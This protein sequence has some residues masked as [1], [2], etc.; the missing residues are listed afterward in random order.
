MT[1]VTQET[2]TYTNEETRTGEVAAL[3]RT[4]RFAIDLLLEAMSLNPGHQ[5]ARNVAQ[6]NDEIEHLKRWL[7][8]EEEPKAKI[9]K[10]SLTRSRKEEP[11]K[12]DF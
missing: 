11:N 12:I 2:Y 6:Y 8:D 7:R 4:A 9:R 10:K 1:N 5:I 3:R